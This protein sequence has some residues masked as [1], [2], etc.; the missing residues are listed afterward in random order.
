MK[1]NTTEMTNEL[2]KKR[3]EDNSEQRAEDTKPA[4][5]PP[6]QSRRP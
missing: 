5:F 6:G 2:L 1:K 4:S 3:D